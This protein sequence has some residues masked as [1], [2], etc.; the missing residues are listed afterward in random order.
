[1]GWI[2]KAE[3]R[4]IRLLAGE[5]MPAAAANGAT[6]QPSANKTNVT[7]LITRL[8]GRVARFAKARPS[9]GR[10]EQPTEG[11]DCVSGWRAGIGCLMS[12]RSLLGR[13]AA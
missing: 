9:R 7:L 10:S 13:R 11:S 3:A 12:E 1:M 8:T 4:N 2:E 6:A 5:A